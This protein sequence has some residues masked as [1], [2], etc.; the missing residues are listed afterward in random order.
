MSVSFYPKR[1]I[2]LFLHSVFREDGPSMSVGYASKAALLEMR[3]L[4]CMIE[5][6]VT[7]SNG[8]VLTSVPSFKCFVKVSISLYLY[9]SLYLPTCPCV[10][11]WYWVEVM[12]KAG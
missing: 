2:Q 11:G 7:Y 6:N 10:V 4:Y 8:L 5:G 12:S 3:E 9:L 1:K